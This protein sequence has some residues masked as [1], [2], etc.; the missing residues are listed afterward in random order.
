MADST[1]HRDGEVSSPPSPTFNTLSALIPPPTASTSLGSPTLQKPR[2]ST[3]HHELSALRGSEQRLQRHLQSYLDAQA[4]GLITGITGDVPQEARDAYVMQQSSSRFGN[5]SGWQSSNEAISLNG[6]R[7]GI[8][9]TMK[10][11]ASIKEDER[12]HIRAEL[13][14][15]DTELRRIDD[16]QEKRT[17]LENQTDSVYRSP[18]GLSLQSL[19]EEDQ[20]LQ[21]QIEAMESKLSELKSQQTIVRSQMSTLKNSVDSASSSYKASLSMLDS[22]TSDFLR[23]PPLFGTAVDAPSTYFFS[24]PR[25]RR[26]LALAKDHFNEIHRAGQAQEAGAE[27]ERLALVDG[28]EVWREIIQ[29]VTDLEDCLKKEMRNVSRSPRESNGPTSLQDGS[30]AQG[31]MRGLLYRMI[32]ITIHLE[33]H[34]EDAQSKGWSLLVCCIGAELE[35]FRQGQ[36]ILQQAL[37]ISEQGAGHFAAGY[38]KSSRGH[39]DAS[40]DASRYL[41]T[42]R[43]SSDESE[44]EI[45]PESL[46]VSTS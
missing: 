25:D 28:A 11:L 7:R 29:D 26:T 10:S 9:S 5:F 16:W 6:A 13:N 8:L 38:P 24:L 37:Q 35:A 34:F 40:S 20:A 23:K 44:K 32:T 43:R 27:K 42:P 22:Q 14:K 31:G 39:C 17:A 2:Y 33:R 18:E 15:V 3:N 19:Q 36:E 12:R 4:D 45:N 1:I 46:L 41:A 21:D 30:R